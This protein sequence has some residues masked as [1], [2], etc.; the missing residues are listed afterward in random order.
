MLYDL[1][2]ERLYAPRT[3]PQFACK[4]LD[5]FYSTRK[6]KKCFVVF[7]DI[8]STPAATSQASLQEHPHRA[9]QEKNIAALTISVQKDSTLQRAADGDVR[10]TSRP[11]LPHNSISSTGAGYPHLRASPPP[12]S[13][14]DPPP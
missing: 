5:I 11:L 12:K 8:V 14:P 13:H 10:P 7:S 1:H 6:Y 3:T 4:M 9:P 2:R